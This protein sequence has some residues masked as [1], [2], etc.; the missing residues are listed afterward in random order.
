MN[1][2]EILII[3]VPML[4]FMGWVYGRIDKKFD[5]ME[6]Q[7][8]QRFEKVDQRFDKIEEKISRLDSRVARIEGHLVG[9]HHWEPKVI[10][11]KEE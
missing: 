1:W 2:Q 5:K 8:D 3:L 7:I 9:M 11:K 6:Q 4:G 10:Q